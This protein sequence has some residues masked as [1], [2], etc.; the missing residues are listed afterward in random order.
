MKTMKDLA[1]KSKEHPEL[2]HKLLW[3]KI[4]VK[5]QIIRL[6]SSKAYEGIYEDLNTKLQSVYT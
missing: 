4:R 3:N 6:R 2:F 1:L 5:I